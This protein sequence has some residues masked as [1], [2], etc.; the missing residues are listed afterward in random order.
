[1]TEGAK[2]PNEAATALRAYFRGK[3]KSESGAVMPKELKKAGMGRKKT[4]H[5]R[6]AP[7]VRPTHTVVKTP[8]V[9]RVG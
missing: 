4:G 1:M 6:Y 2:K 5:Q 7:V 3:E 9:L 8:Q